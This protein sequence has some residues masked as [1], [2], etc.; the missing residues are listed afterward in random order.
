MEPAQVIQV[1]NEGFDKLHTKIDKKFD[2]CDERLAHVETKLAVKD[3][4]CKQK[5]EQRDYWQ[6]TIRTITIA[7]IIALLSIAW[8][9]MKAIL[10][11]V[12]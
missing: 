5:K 2:E 11:L 3:A 9:K 10:D 8:E 1:I 12:T 7:G 6:I 4:L